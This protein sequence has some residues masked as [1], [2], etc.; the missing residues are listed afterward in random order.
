MKRLVITSLAVFALSV[1]FSQETGKEGVRINKHSG[2]KEKVIVVRPQKKVAAVKVAD[3][4]TPPK[5][6]RTDRLRKE[7][8]P[9]IRKHKA[10][11]Q[12]KSRMAPKGN[13]KTK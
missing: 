4:K 2:L 5:K 7:A 9:L 8:K 11:K 12:S 3:V 13:F 10:T 1:S 6:I